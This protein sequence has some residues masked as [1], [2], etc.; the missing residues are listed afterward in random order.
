MS[1][2]KGPHSI[3]SPGVYYLEPSDLK[4]MNPLLIKA[5]GV[6][7]KYII[8]LAVFFLFRYRERRKGGK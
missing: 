8:E 2:L 3:S 5:A 1:G 4:V 6:S 7:R